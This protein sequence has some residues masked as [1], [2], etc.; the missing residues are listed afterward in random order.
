MQRLREYK[1]NGIML[2]SCLYF[3]NLNKLSIKFAENFLKDIEFIDV[4]KFGYCHVSGCLSHNYKS[5][6]VPYSELLS[7][8]VLNS[9]SIEKVKEIFRLSDGCIGFCCN[10]CFN[11]LK[12]HVAYLTGNL[13]V[14]EES[15]YDN[16][17]DNNN[18]T[19]QFTHTI[20]N[21]NF[22]NFLENLNKVSARVAEHFTKKFHFRKSAKFFLL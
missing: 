16:I 2:N 6:L 3:E 11:N 18:N 19:T 22:C 9:A 13:I 14:K 4:T 20:N 15:I 10:D 21:S 17:Q 1:V 5:T 12:L 8:K 7:E